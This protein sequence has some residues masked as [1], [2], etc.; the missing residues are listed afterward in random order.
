MKKKKVTATKSGQVDTAKEKK[1]GDSHQ[2]W[3]RCHS[4]HRP[5]G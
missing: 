3:A 1:K 5:K 4:P 2:I